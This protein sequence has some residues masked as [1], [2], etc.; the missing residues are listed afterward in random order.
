MYTKEIKSSELNSVLNAMQCN[1][2]PH[3]VD[4]M[5]EIPTPTHA[6]STKY[7]ITDAPGN[8][9]WYFYTFET[10]PVML[11]YIQELLNNLDLTSGGDDEYFDYNPAQLEVILYGLYQLQGMPGIN[12][13]FTQLKQVFDNYFENDE[14]HEMDDTYQ[15]Y[16]DNIN[17]QECS[18]NIQCLEISNL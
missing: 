8:D 10:F 6:I 3:L 17:F 7:H 5:G 11:Q 9:T 15:N 14:L 1:S 13:L 12:Q 4:Y 16:L 2:V 18:I